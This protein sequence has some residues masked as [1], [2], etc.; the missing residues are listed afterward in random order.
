MM[1]PNDRRLSV[2]GTGRRWPV[3]C[4]NMAVFG[5]FLD[6]YGRGWTGKWSGSGNRENLPNYLNKSLLLP[7]SPMVEAPCEAPKTTESTGSRHFLG[8]KVTPV[9]LR[10]HYRQYQK[11]CWMSSNVDGLQRDTRLALASMHRSQLSRARS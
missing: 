6:A 7:I 10:Y 1:A 3:K 9:V 5:V 2:N 4:S 11:C 8:T